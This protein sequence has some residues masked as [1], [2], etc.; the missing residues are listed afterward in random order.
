MTEVGASFAGY[1]LE[2]LLSTD[3]VSSI[4]RAMRNGQGR[5]T[6]RPLSLRVTHELCV[7]DRPD[8]DAI[9]AYIR[10][11]SAAVKVAHPALVP[12]ADA[13]DHDDR[14]YVATALVD[15]VTLDRYVRATGRLAPDDAIALLR[16]LALALDAAHAAGVVHGAISPRTIRIRRGAGGVPVAVL[17]GFGVDTLLAR[18]ARIDRAVID[19]H[20]VAY[21]SPEHLRGDAVDGR[22]DQYA[23]ACALFHCVTGQP[24]FR[25][26]TAAGLFG[27]HLFGVVP[28]APADA[29]DRALPGALAAGMAKSPDDRHATCVDLL[30]AT[31]HTAALRTPSR[32]TAPAAGS[33]R[34]GGVA[35]PD[36]PAASGGT[37][38]AASE[39]VPP[40]RRRRGLRLGGLGWPA[41]TWPVAAMLVL[42]GII[43]TLVFVTVVRDRD[44]AAVDGITDPAGPVVAGSVARSGD[45][46]AAAGVR[47]QR[48]VADEP[49]YDVQVVGD[50]VIA[51]APHRVLAVAA[52]GGA[53]SWSWPV[54]VGVLTDVVATDV[55]VALRAAKFRALATV[56]GTSQWEKP[57][58]VAPINTLATSDGTIYGVGVGRLAPQLQAIDAATGRLLWSYDGGD[59]RI[60]DG[61]SVVALD[62]TVAMLDSDRLWVVD[63]DGPR[64]DDASPAA[65]ARW[66]VTLT[67]PWLDSLA[68][69]P[70]VVAVATRS[71]EVCAYDPADGELRWCEAVAGI[72]EVAPTIVAVRDTLAVIGADV[73][74][75]AIEN[76][77][78]RWTF[79]APRDLTPV[80]AGTA[81]QLVVS[82]VDGRAHGLDLA[83]GFE[84]WRASGFGRITA[85]AASDDAVYAGTRAGLLV[86]VE[87]TIETPS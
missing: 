82:D 52:D 46:P 58:I 1:R 38:A 76:G 15:G 34:A 67:D 33:A 80:A 53:T 37:T 19:V 71:G 17:D 14:A 12:I 72:G 23:V 39:H 74:A 27:A 84:V 59:A 25:R 49:V 69:L 8:A 60:D 4:Y 75:L 79:D 51:A 40:T 83:T 21:V 32:S 78:P 7:A 36:E 85:L 10:S 77:A 18:Q 28:T 29:D 5:P 73:T 47:W 65:G 68:V 57:D 13:G 86:R 62:G 50:T 56:D 9:A 48:A 55:V 24:P 22:T 63:A 2:Q 30:R 61:A 41:L 20:D 6:S 42:A 43:A 54:D 87:P 35:W 3:T 66:Q 70:D 45:R 11:V 16:D 31:G 81:A 64:A 44:L 26:D